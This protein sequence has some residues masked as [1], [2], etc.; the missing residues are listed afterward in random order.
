MCDIYSGNIYCIRANHMDL[1]C[2][3]ILLPLWAKMYKE[4][5]ASLSNFYCTRSWKGHAWILLLF[6]L[7]TQMMVI[8]SNT[9]IHFSRCVKTAE[10]KNGIL[11]WYYPSEF[12]H[13]CWITLWMHMNIK[14]LM[15]SAESLMFA[16]Q[17]NI[18]YHV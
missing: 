2:I 6:S 18:V 10:K 17:L 3:K 12:K 13:S 8:F 9:P 5:I 7:L 15:Q 16:Q 4:P 14:M 1:K 11:Q